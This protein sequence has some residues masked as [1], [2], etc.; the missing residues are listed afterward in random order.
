MLFLFMAAL[1]AFAQPI[2]KLTTIIISDNYNF[3]YLQNEY[4]V[5]SDSLIITAINDKGDTRIEYLKK[6]LAPAETNSLRE[7]L[8]SYRHDSLMPE[9]FGDLANLGYI[10]YDH[11][12]RII[13]I[14]LQGPQLLKKVKVTNCYVQKAASLIQFL[15]SLFPPEMRIKYYEKDFQKIFR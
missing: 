10:A 8:N 1:S 11:F 15:N 4:L 6:Q 3:Q 12:P 13:N 2:H 14:T 5:T 9:Y 7:F